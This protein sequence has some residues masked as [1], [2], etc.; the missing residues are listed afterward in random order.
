M[1]SQLPDEE[2]R[3]GDHS[4]SVGGREEG[5]REDKGDQAG[6]RSGENFSSAN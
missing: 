2:S 5:G 6:Q 1:Y 4:G 3:T